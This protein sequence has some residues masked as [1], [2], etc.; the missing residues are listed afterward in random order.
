[1]NP[2]QCGDSRTTTDYDNLRAVIINLRTMEIEKCISQSLIGCGDGK[3]DSSNGETCD[4]GNL[5]SG[6]GCSSTCQMETYY[7]CT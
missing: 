7:T 3:Y 5:V 6:D 1:L 4:D 2:G